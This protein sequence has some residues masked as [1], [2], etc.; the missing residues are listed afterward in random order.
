MQDIIN[1]WLE[2]REMFGPGIFLYL[3]TRRGIESYLENK[4]SNL[5]IGL[6]ALHRAIGKNQKSDKVREKVDRIMHDVVLP[7]DKRWLKNVLKAEPSLAERI[8]DLF[9]TLPVSIA[10]EYL[11]KFADSCARLRNDL[12]HFGTTREKTSYEQFAHDTNKI[13]RALGILYHLKILQEIGVPD[14]LLTW[15]FTD[16]FTSYQ[17][18]AD[19]WLAGLLPE[20]PQILRQQRRR[21]DANIS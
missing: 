9:G 18:Q 5:V 1:N 19:L 8:S 17:I 2:K 6:E 4:F 21:N 3:G 20:D 15:I 10:P 16:G 14:A 13:T 11:T 7:G 12:S